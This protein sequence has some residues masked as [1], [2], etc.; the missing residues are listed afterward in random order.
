MSFCKNGSLATFAIVFYCILLIG[1]AKSVESMAVSEPIKD[2]NN[3]V[4]FDSSFGVNKIINKY[5]NG[6]NKYIDERK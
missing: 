6:W 5:E 1:Y 2:S 3:V 4:N